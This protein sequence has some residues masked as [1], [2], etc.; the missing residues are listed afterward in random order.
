MV[1][2]AIFVGIALRLWRLD[3]IPFGIDTEEAEIL[4][5][6]AKSLAE[7]KLW[8]YSPVATQWENLPGILFSL[9][10]GQRLLPALLGIGE[11]FACAWLGRVLLGTREA[12]WRAAA[13]LALCPWHLYY[14]RTFSTAIGTGLLLCWVLAAPHAGFWS[15]VARSVLGLLWYTIFRLAFVRSL[16]SRR[17]WVPG[18]VA[19]AL[20]LAILALSD[21]SWK[22][23]FTRG[24][25]NVASSTASVWRNLGA[26]LTT[27]L[28]GIPTAFEQARPGFLADSVHASFARCLMGFPPLGLGLVAAL[29]FVRRPPT[30]LRRELVFLVGAVFLLGLFGPQLSRFLCLLPLIA[31]AGAWGTGR[32]R[33]A[34]A[35][36]LVANALCLVPL[37]SGVSDPA[38][39]EAYFHPRWRAID[40]ILRREPPP[41]VPVYAWA[42]AGYSAARHWQEKP[43]APYTLLPPFDP[44]VLEASLGEGAVIVFSAEPSEALSVAGDFRPVSRYRA[45][46]AW[47]ERHPA[48]T[49]RRPLFFDGRWVGTWFRIGRTHDSPKRG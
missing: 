7:G 2:V 41:G 26:T 4:Y 10:G 38:R 25:Y 24:A 12:G 17:A 22:L 8:F 46:Y 23:F 37:F 44:A 39:M 19:G 14:S 16:F 47:A 49:E 11:I 1:W 43:G 13:I 31:V 34:F 48:L 3:S 5:W 33:I 21:S 30:A 18:L 27:F 45:A 29:C 32:S 20:V 42:E 36:V 6:G 40:S 15:Q 9:G 35:L 28:V